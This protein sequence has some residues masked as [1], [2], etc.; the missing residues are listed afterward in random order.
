MKYTA[1]KQNHKA[2]TVILIVLAVL[3]AAVGVLSWMVLNDPNAGKGLENIQASDALPKAVAKSAVT[4]QES[5]FSVDEVNGYLAYLFQKSNVSKK[6]GSMKVQAVAISNASGSSADLYLPVSY[7]GKHLGVVLN[8]TPSLDSTNN[9][10]LFQVNSAQVGRL[11]VPAGWALE[12]V[13]SHLPE[14]FSA[15]D[16]TISCESPAIEASVSGITASL[17]VGDFKMENGCL[18]IGSQAEIK[19]G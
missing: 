19:I 15:S 17:K 16:N 1:N 2:V 14:G 8:V 12:K 4:R 13:R 7:Q 6:D 5:S 3:I 10:L 9:K 11:P 18:K